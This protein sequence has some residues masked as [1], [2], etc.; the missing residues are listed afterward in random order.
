M[1]EH[2]GRNKKKKKLFRGSS[3]THTHRR[4][5]HLQKKKIF[6]IKT[7]QNISRTIYIT[8][9]IILE[10]CQSERYIYFYLRKKIFLFF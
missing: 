1:C 7:L 3:H 2:W 6:F 8:W 9:R 4:R 10:F 5:F